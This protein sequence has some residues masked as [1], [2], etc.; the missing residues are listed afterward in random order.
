MPSF[1]GDPIPLSLISRDISGQPESCVILH[2]FGDWPPAA[3]DVALL[4]E[5]LLQTSSVSVKHWI[6]GIG[7]L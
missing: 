6:E 5:L 7:Q 3:L 2:V 4:L 1:T